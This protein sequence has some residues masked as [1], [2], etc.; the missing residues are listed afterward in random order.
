MA[1]RPF[2]LCVQLV[3]ATDSTAAG[4][5]STAGTPASRPRWARR[6]CAG[7]SPTRGPTQA[8]MLREGLLVAGLEQVGEA[9]L[10]LEPGDE[11][12]LVL[13]PVGEAVL[14]VLDLEQRPVAGVDGL[15]RQL[16]GLGA[17]GAPAARAGREDVEEGRAVDVASALAALRTR[18]RG[19][20]GEAW[21]TY[22]RP[23]A[24]MMSVRFLRFC[25]LPERLLAH[26]AGGGP[27]AHAAWR[28]S[29]GSR[30]SCRRRCRSRRRACR[31]RAPWRRRATAGRCRRCRRRRRRR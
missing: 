9:A 27:G 17:V 26:R 30:C 31:G 13:R 7:A 10:A 29:A 12:Q 19:S 3:A 14:A 5:R 11:R 8:S 15:A 18:S 23:W 25:S 22:W 21:A 4:T 2:G 24:I 20:C 6:T 1:P 16:D 28:P